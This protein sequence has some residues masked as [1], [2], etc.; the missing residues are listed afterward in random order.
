MMLEDASRLF[1]GSLLGNRWLFALATCRPGNFKLLI[2]SWAVKFLGERVLSIVPLMSCLG[3]KVSFWDV[4]VEI[5]IDGRIHS[6]PRH[7]SGPQ[8]F[9]SK[10]DA[11]FQVISRV[12]HEGVPY[13]ENI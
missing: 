11:I 6:R 2:A 12:Q 5:G 7:A 4:I 3:N 9:Q 8:V 13:H 1:M 10:S